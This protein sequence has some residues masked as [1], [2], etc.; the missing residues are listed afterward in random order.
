MRSGKLVFEFPVFP[1][2]HWHSGKPPFIQH[3]NQSSGA[4]KESTPNAQPGSKVL[5]PA[6]SLAFGLGQYTQGN[7]TNFY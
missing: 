1:S 7:G 4:G 6:T 3:W 2:C 5:G